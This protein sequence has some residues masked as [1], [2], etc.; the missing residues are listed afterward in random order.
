[1]TKA[2][3][4]AA[5]YA[6]R[7]YPLTK[8]YPKPLLEIREKPIIEYITDNLNAAKEIGEILVI[9]NSKFFPHFQRWRK[10]ARLDKPLRI[11]DDLTKDNAARLGAV[12]DIHFA[13][14]KEKLN[15]DLL[16]VGGDNI[17][18][19][20]LDDF[21]AFAGD[22]EECPTI[23]VYDIGEAKKAKKYGV[24]KMDAQN[25]VTV[26][27]EKPREPLSS[28]VAMCLYY[29]P[30]QSLRLIKEYMGKGNKNSDTTGS[31]IDWLRKKTAVY[32]F[33]FGGRW[34]DIGDIKFYN[35]AKFK[36][37]EG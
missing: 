5:G 10:K 24:I 28:L 22:K 9:T 31:Y 34:Y 17:F 18:D 2:L 20:S 25:K 36:F 33:V 32:A 30:A 23:G 14:E 26:F 3:I 35:E 11:I 16:V 37:R 29:F 27:Q 19:N 12:G 15:Q 6:T 8:E 1:M 13:I 4:L 21:I 7:L